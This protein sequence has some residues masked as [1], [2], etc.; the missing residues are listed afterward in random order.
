M[1]GTEWKIFREGDGYYASLSAD[2][3]SAQKSI[4]MEA[5]ILEDDEIGGKIL[6]TLAKK[7]AQGIE[8]RVIVDG[9]G[10][11]RLSAE[12]IAR[13]RAAGVDIN[14]FRPV[15]IFG[16]LSPRNRRR[17][18]RKLTVIDEMICYI[19]GMNISRVHS[20][21]AMGHDAWRDC[22]IR[23]K[24]PIAGDAQSSFNRLNRYV[25]RKWFFFPREKQARDT[26]FQLIENAPRFKREFRKDYQR[27]IRNAKNR[28][29]I[30]SAYFI[31]TP[32][33]LRK[34][35]KIARAGV[36][37]R[38][39]L[40]EKSDVPAARWASHAVYQRL[41][42]RG[43]RIFEHRSRFFHSKSLIADD[44]I[45]LIGSANLDHRSFLHDLEISVICRLPEINRA[46]ASSFLEDCGDSREILYRAWRNRPWIERIIEKFFYFF[47]YYL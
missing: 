27:L 39:L 19:G 15:G 32:P 6:D 28:V 31:P 16:L 9:V 47:R 44:E 13:L 1:E 38:I 21:S 30:V 3:N 41:L 23:L 26:L 29:W 43:V 45:S 25:K 11:H 20:V 34:L 10:S 24:G 12:R 5:Y 22:T 33:L 37:V 35:K 40:S 2:L 17:S 7:A 8:V 46:L 36:D 4:C 14:F 42:K 18:H